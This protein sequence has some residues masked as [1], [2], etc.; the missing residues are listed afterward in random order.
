[1]VESNLGQR[2]FRAIP[3]MGMALVIPALVW[4]FWMGG[5]SHVWELIAVAVFL[6]GALVAVVSDHALG[7]RSRELL[8]K[9][10]ERTVVPGEET[11]LNTWMRVPAEQIETVVDELEQIAL[12]VE[13]APLA[14]EDER[15]P[16]V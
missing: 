11:S 3:L 4:V 13:G 16:G 15:G 1:V 14:R 12:E 7:R 2:L 8:A 10:L 5:V 6:Y 9:A